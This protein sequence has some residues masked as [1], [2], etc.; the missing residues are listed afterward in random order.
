MI[1]RLPAEAGTKALALLE[2]GGLRPSRARVAILAH[3]AARPGCFCRF[4][5][6]VRHMVLEHHGISVTSAYHVL[7]GLYQHGLI[8]RCRDSEGKYAYRWRPSESKHREIEFVDGR[9]RALC[10]VQDGALLDHLERIALA[11][12]IE[13]PPGRWRVTLLD[14]DEQ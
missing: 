7:A 14:A 12:G 2:S 9:G 13:H 8:E 3:L 4:D 10:R 5:D 6:L 11:E 1:A